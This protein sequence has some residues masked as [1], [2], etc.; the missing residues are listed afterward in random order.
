[1]PVGQPNLDV[2]RL[3]PPRLGAAVGQVMHQ[4]IQNNSPVELP[5]LWLEAEGQAEHI[6]VVARPV[7]AVNSDPIGDPCI[8]V[9][10][11]PVQPSSAQP[12]GASP[13]P[14]EL[15]PA[16]L[17]RLAALEREL[18][19]TRLTLQTTVEE[20]EAANEELQA[21]NEELMSANEELQ[22]TNEELQSVNEELY[23]V[24]S[25]YN[26]KLDEVNALHDD[27]MGMS[28]ATGIATLFVDQTLALIRFT[29]EA[30]LLFP[31]RPGDV[32]RPVADFKCRLEYPQLLEDLQ[33]AV[34]GT[35]LVER[36]VAG[37]AGV[38][39]LS[40]VLAYGETTSRGRRA[41]MSLI[42]VSRVHD[43]MRLQLMMNGLHDPVAVVDNFGIIIKV[44]R[45]WTE[46]GRANAPTGVV[47]EPGDTSVGTNYLRVLAQSSEP[48]SP[49]LLRELQALLQGQRE[50]LRWTYPCHSPDRQ[51]WFMMRARRMRADPATNES[52]MV[53]SHTDIT[54]WVGPG[55]P[56]ELGE[57]T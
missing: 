5:P 8:L 17:D 27:L 2:M 38:R 44:N 50:D 13:T 23:T 35:G 29:P 10:L 52:G 45:A 51:R 43:A 53:I 22:S 12:S 47:P 56:A 21:T 33:A 54:G 26:A 7:A 28:L 20:T 4:V 49:A 16:Q 25:E 39:Y 37:P 36:E 14:R 24:N 1:M 11:A 18:S 31:L 57:G 9:T 19:D 30:S 3:L 15:D 40:R 55:G 42:D 34:G 48:D 46:F 6:R 32:G 41:V